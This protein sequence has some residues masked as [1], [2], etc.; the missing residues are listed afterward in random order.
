MDRLPRKMTEYHIK[1]IISS[2]GKIKMIDVPIEKMLPP[3]GKTRP[4][5][6]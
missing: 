3:Y 4:L 2:C 6:R 5:W 1:E